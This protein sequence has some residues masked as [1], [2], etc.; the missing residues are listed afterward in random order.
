MCG[1]CGYVG[2]GGKDLL[3]A[4][5]TALA[6]RG[7]DGS[8]EFIEGDVGLAHRRLAIID[9]SENAAQPMSNEDGSLHLVFNG[10]IYNHGELRR[11]FSE[12]GH[13]F[14][15]VCDAEVV[16]HAYEEFGERCVEHFN[17]M[18]A[19]AIWDSKK[20]ILF[21]G[22]DRFGMRPFYYLHA[23]GKFIFASE[24]KAILLWQGVSRDPD[25]VAID[26][27]LTFRSVS[28]QRTMFPQIKRLEP[29]H[30]MIFEN[31]EVR[32]RCYWELSFRESAQD[33]GDW[34]ERFLSLFNE[35]VGMR[36]MSDVPYGAHISGGI[37]SS[38]VASLM[39]E[40]ASQKLRLFSV[41]F[42]TEHDEL[43]LARAMA[44]SLG[45]EFN[46]II[47]GADD[48][49][50]LP[51]IVYHL[52]EPLGDAIVI[53]IYLLAKLSGEKVKVVLTGEGA[54]EMF[55]AY[56]HHGAVLKGDAMREKHSSFVRDKVLANLVRMAP[57]SVLDWFFEY[58]ASLG[59][60]GKK[61]LVNFIYD[62]GDRA[63]MYLGA[64]S[65]F[66]SKERAAMYS[67]E[68]YERVKISGAEESRESSIRRSLETKDNES[69]LN[70]VIDYDMRHWLHDNILF[71]QDKL[72]MA[73]SV[74]GRYP[75]LDHRLVELAASLPVSLKRSWSET[76]ILLRRAMKSRLPKATVARKKQSF[77]FPTEKVFGKA[78]EEK[79][80]SV[81]SPEN[82]ARRGYCRPEFVARL[83]E[84]LNGRELI[85]NKQIFA[86]L[87][88]ELWHRI[89]VDGEKESWI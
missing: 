41:G 50:L 34:A 18:F 12:A 35:S 3:N 6:H 49:R 47:V 21:A 72:C 32:S 76:K 82:I 44:R 62:T 9:L 42:G 58:P 60:H 30:T 16:L 13:H 5:S 10:E 29:A 36:L 2:I 39:S 11:R 61:R 78:F 83:L 15:S 63:R 4:M 88:L 89:F 69:L 57:V 45:A 23:D 86:L 55:G 68:F 43:D 84:R 79:V 71:K 40:H 33:S 17:G 56:V 85:F 19:F 14:R 46:E 59:E 81:L 67:D 26:E 54:D 37:D 22:R 66:N 74:E 1:I 25:P 24:T 70:R 87:V 73:H 53:P 38:A 28:R 31:G 52:D 8:G 77:Y 64:A 20:K 27:F 7:P 65:L 80:R 48:F 75:F 51:E